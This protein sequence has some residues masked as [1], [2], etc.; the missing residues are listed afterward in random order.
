MKTL[1]LSLI[2]TL[3][4]N[5]YSQ[6][7]YVPDYEFELYLETHSSSYAPPV[8]LGDPNSMGN[9]VM[10]NYVPTEKIDTVTYLR[11]F[12][13]NVWPWTPIENLIGIE[14]FVAL[15]ELFCWY[16]GSGSLGFVD[17]SNNL[18]LKSIT[19]SDN[20]I[21]TLILGNNSNLIYVS[22]SDNNLYSLDV[23]NNPALES[24]S[25]SDNNLSSLDVSN[26]TALTYL[27]CDDNQLTSLDV[28][29]NPALTRLGC[30]YNQLTCLNLKNGNNTN[31][32]CVRAIYG[33]PNLT[34]VEVDDV[35]YCEANWL[36][37]WNNECYLGLGQNGVPLSEDC[38]G[39]GL[40]SGCTIGTEEL[41]TTPK[42]LL[43]IVD[44]M[45][46]ETTFKPN[47]PLIYLYDDGSTE[48][49][50]KIE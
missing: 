4:F 36:W 24:L 16:E 12:S 35:S 37:D 46:R 3:S 15:E 28:S 32:T 22:C 50:F 19:L 9:G 39:A 10:D 40:W 5:S 11:P 8:P 31:M 7:T 6:L 44:L 23:S 20:D 13:G 27:W 25:C 17:L 21:S 33:N 14:D 41:T 30:T 49:V 34:C 48:R 29:N 42:Q 45:G 1:L 47:T 38:S 26:N 43:K 2:I 18:A